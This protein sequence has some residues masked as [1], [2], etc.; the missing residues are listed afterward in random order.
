LGVS[1]K[2][3]RYEAATDNTNAEALADEVLAKVY[4]FA[5]ITCANAHV[6]FR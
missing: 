3:K 2:R 4:K 1:E 6:Q 5:V